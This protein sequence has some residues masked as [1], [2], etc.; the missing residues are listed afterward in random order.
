MIGF[1][2]NQSPNLGA[3]QKLSQ[4]IC[5][6]V[7]L[8][9]HLAE[10]SLVAQSVKNLPAMQE[11]WVGSPC[12]EDPWQRKWLPIPVFL[13]GVLHGHSSRAG[14]HPCSHKESDATE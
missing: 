6:G 4:G 11:T 2:G 13:P 9:G 3:F 12:Q 1:P 14:Y 7:E 8:L 10:A 5:P